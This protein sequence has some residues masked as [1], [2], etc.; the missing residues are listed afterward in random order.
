MPK[1]QMRLWRAIST[2]T[3]DCFALFHSA[4]NDDRR[5]LVFRGDSLIVS[6][7]K[8]LCNNYYKKI[9]QGVTELTDTLRAQGFT[10]NFLEILLGGYKTPRKLRF[11]P[12]SL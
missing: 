3:R 9:L 12:F 5:L 6:E 8:S 1:L 11:L 4:R 7:F 10:E 2:G